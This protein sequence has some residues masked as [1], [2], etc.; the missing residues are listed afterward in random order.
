MSKMKYKAISE[1]IEL[2]TN[3]Y[4]LPTHWAGYFVNGDATGYESDELERIEQW[5]RE[6]P[7]EYCVAVDD[8]ADFCVEGDDDE[9]ACERCLYVFEK[10]QPFGDY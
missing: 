5:E 7:E 8:E 4:R 3:E 6:H 2:V 1:S 10:T 9:L